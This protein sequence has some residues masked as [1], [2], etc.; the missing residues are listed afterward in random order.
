MLGCACECQYLGVKGSRVQIPPSRL[1]FERS[2]AMYSSST[3]VPEEDSYCKVCMRPLSGRHAADEF[4]ITTLGRGGFASR[5]YAFAMRAG[6]HLRRAPVAGMPVQWASAPCS[7]WHRD[8]HLGGSSRHMAVPRLTSRT[9]T[10]GPGC[11]ARDPPIC[12]DFDPMPI[13]VLAAQIGSFCA[14]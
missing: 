3:A 12:T 8:P 6:R 2:F 1:F 5:C 13:E 9:V 10:A 14:V 7:P 11:G 4:K